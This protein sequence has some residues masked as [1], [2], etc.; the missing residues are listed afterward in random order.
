MESKTFPKQWWNAVIDGLVNRGIPV[1]IIG[2]TGSPGVLDLDDKAGVI[3]LVDLLDLGG[4]TALL[5][6]AKVLLSNDSGPVHLAGAF[7][8]WIVAIPTVK[9]P[10]HFLPFRNGVTSYKTVAPMKKLVL[11]AFSTAPTE[12]DKVTVSHIKGT[13]D[14]YLVDPKDIVDIVAAKYAE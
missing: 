9:H 6:Q 10:D 3:N 13:W 12:L 5:S 2:K 8:N 11:D 4:L 14:D 1:C 7:D